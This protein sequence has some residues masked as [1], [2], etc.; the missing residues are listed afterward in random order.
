MADATHVRVLSFTTPVAG[1]ISTLVTVGFVLSTF[2]DA[3]SVAVPEYP[4]VA[5]VVQVT[6]SPGLAIEASSVRLAAVPTRAEPTNH[7]YDTVGVSPSASAA[8]PVHV[9]VV[10]VLT[11]VVGLIEAVIV[12]FR[13]SI[14]MAAFALSLPPS[15]SVA[16]LLYTSPSPRD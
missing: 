13:L 1:R 10:D 15:A 6:V 3:L 9:K 4:S 14:D 7:A 8:V 2:T 5:V 12:G 16:C 11:P